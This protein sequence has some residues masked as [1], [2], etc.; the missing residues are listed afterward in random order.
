MQDLQIEW[1]ILHPG[2]LFIPYFPTGQGVHTPFSKYP[3]FGS[4]SKQSLSPCP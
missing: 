3:I 2:G 4:Q 1:Q